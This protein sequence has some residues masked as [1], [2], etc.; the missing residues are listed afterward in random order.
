MCSDP[1]PSH[2]LRTRRAF[3]GSDFMKFIALTASFQT[4]LSSGLIF[5]EARASVYYSVSTGCQDS[6][7]VCARLG[8]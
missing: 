6:S 2:N 4:E 3:S 7:V 5:F 1:I 8:L